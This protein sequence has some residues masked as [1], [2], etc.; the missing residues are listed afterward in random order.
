MLMSVVLPEP[1]A[2]IRATISPRLTVS[3]TPF[4]TGTPTLP[5]QEVL[6]MASSRRDVAPCTSRWRPA[7]ASRLTAARLMIRLTLLRLVVL[8]LGQKRRGRVVGGPL[9]GLADDDL[10]PLVDVAALDLGVHA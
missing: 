6:R 1:E 7:V 2:P 10:G 4:R 5:R 8:E 9:L 3:D